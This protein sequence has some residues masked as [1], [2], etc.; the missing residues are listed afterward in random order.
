MDL[1]CFRGN[2][3]IVIINIMYLE[4]VVFLRS[5]KYCIYIILFFFVICEEGE[6]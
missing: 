6:R 5:L 1:V 2:R 3:N 4:S